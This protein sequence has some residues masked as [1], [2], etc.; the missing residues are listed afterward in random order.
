MTDA[1][2]KRIQA[3]LSVDFEA[4]ILVGIRRGKRKQHIIG[5]CP[6]PLDAESLN[7]MLT[8]APIPEPAPVTT[9]VLPPKL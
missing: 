2:G 3:S 7:A 4:F 8:V 1:F 6:N 5:Y 9:S